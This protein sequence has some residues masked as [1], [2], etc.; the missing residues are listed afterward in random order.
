MG[1][2]QCLLDTDRKVSA[3]QTL[4]TRFGEADGNSVPP[5]VVDTDHDVPPAFLGTEKTAE[6]PKLV[7]P[8]A[9]ISAEVVRSILHKLPSRPLYQKRVCCGQTHLSSSSWCDGQSLSEP[10]DRACHCCTQAG[11]Q[12]HRPGTLPT[13]CDSCPGNLRG[14]KAQRD[15]DTPFPFRNLVS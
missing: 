4:D 5:D 1:L 8:S 15:A 14:L 13:P 10:E 6:S 3:E 12:W 2:T 9:P 11:T 7:A